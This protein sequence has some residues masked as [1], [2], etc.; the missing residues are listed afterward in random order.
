MAI[1]MDSVNGSEIFQIVSEIE[2]MLETR[3]TGGIIA[4][5]QKAVPSYS[6]SSQRALLPSEVLPLT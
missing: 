3:N 4:T 6:P 1:Q 2:E 5:L